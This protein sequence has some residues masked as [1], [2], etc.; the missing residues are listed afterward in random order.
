MS[1]ML[2]KYTSFDHSETF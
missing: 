2:Q 1:F